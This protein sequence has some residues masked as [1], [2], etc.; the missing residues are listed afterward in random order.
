M[1]MALSMFLKV[2]E[3]HHKKTLSYI[4]NIY[5]KFFKKLDKSYNNLKICLMFFL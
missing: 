3:I 5:F 1:L 4:I 2:A